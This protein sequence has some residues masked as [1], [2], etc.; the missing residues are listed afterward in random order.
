MSEKSYFLYG[1]SVQGIQDF[2]FRTNNL[3]EIIGASRLVEKVCTTMFADKIEKGVHELK[4]DANAIVNAAGN[5]KYIFSDYDSCQKVVR[6]FP[7]QVETMAPGI[8]ISQA[9]VKMSGEYEDFSNAVDELERRLHIQRNRPMNHTSPRFMGVARSK[10]TNLPAVKFANGK[11]YD[12]ASVQRLNAYRSNNESAQTSYGTDY[13]TIIHADGNA[14]GALFSRFGNDQSKLKEFSSG[15]DELVKK[16]V[17]AAKTATINANYRNGEHINVIICSGD[18]LTVM[19]ESRYALPFVK[20]YMELL[21]KD[22]KFLLDKIFGEDRP[23]PYITACAGIAFLGAKNT[24]R[25]GY[26]LANML[27]EHAKNDSFQHR[28]GKVL[29][30]CLLFYKQAGVIVGNL[31]SSYYQAM[32]PAKGHSFQFG[33]YYLNE[34]NNRWT[35]KR[36]LELSSDSNNEIGIRNNLFDWVGWMN[37]DIDRSELQRKHI[38]GFQGTQK[39]SESTSPEFRGKA[40]YYVGFDLMTYLSV[41]SNKKKRN[42]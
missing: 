23:Y 31:E 41:L 13:D 4:Q 14:M 19:C 9:V 15:L 37:D 17:E 10:D 2:I 27:C 39:F 33:P 6:D 36:F 25:D 28:Q 8:T 40:Y 16:C 3:E 38:A 32:H 35:I 30:S 26:R 42:K 11:R 1:A 18:D 20:N 5:I 21:E 7:K 22:S 12:A 29:P 34:T 24:F